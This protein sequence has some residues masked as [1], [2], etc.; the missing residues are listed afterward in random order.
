[1]D[2]LSPPSPP[3]TILPLPPSL[4]EA[5]TYLRTTL[6]S[7]RVSMRDSFSSRI[8]ISIDHFNWIILGVLTLITIY[9]KELSTNSK[10]RKSVSGRRSNSSNS[11]PSNRQMSGDDADDNRAL[12]L[13]GLASLSV[14][15]DEVSEN[16]ALTMLTSKI[17][18]A[19]TTEVRVP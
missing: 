3:H 16:T 13:R 5:L 11:Y 14:D 2:P 12:H 8:P 18:R 6:T 9:R 17:S 4:T 19:M 1:M 15:D 10:H 7:F